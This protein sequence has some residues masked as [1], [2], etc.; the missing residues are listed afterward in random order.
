M[1]TRHSWSGIRG[2]RPLTAAVMTAAL[3]AA[4]FHPASAQ[5]DESGVDGNTYTGPNFGWSVEWD[6]DVLE[7]AEEDNTGG[8]DF[9]LLKTLDDETPAA[10]FR[11]FADDGL[12]ADPEECVEGWGERTADVEGNEDVEVTEEYDVPP[13]P[14]GGASITYTYTWNN[15]AGRT[16]P[17]VEYY[18]CQWIEE[19]GP[20]LSVWVFAEERYFED[21][22]PLYEDLVETIVIP[23]PSRDASNENPNDDNGGDGNDDSN[24]DQ[25]SEIAASGLDGNQYLS[26]TYGFSVEWDDGIWTAYPDAELIND[27]DLGHDRLYLEH[28]ED[29]AL[30]SGFYIEAKTDYEGDVTECVAA[31]ADLFFDDT[32]LLDL[33]PFADDLGDPIAGASDAGGEY[34]AFYASYEDE[35]GEAYELIW[36]LECQTLAEGESVAIFSL[37]AGEADYEAELAL[38]QDVIASLER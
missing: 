28:V 13:A 14:R 18:Q 24:E 33:Q 29:G 27:G 3:L 8:V 21:A 35:D 1:N 6:E 36:H 4:C 11:F 20:L 15:G 38:A 32:A 25:D 7:F 10:F 9:L 2:S 34:A 22:I 26:P 23:E 31:E 16:F 17:N 19:D 12:F 37:F 5:D 30:Y